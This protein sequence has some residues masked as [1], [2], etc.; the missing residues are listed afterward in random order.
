MFYLALGSCLIRYYLIFYNVSS[1][2]GWSVVLYNTIKHLAGLTPLA[3][4][5]YATSTPTAKSA[6]IRMFSSYGFVKAL[7]PFKAQVEASIPAQWV[8]LFERTKTSFAAVGWQTALVQSFAVLEV[9]HVLLGWVR[10]PLITTA[11]QVAS[12]L[13][14]VWVIAD[15]FEVVGES[16]FSIFKT[17]KPSYLLGT[18]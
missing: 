8:P 14:L 1:A 12:R 2:I 6:L 4:V 13:N 18:I 10:S 7:L 5:A 16:Q 3:Q 9:L 11:L 17:S 15:R